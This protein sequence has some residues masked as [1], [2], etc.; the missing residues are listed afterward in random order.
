[1]DNDI[2]KY[3]SSQSKLDKEICELLMQEISKNL[4]KSES[5]IWHG[6]P[7]WFLNGNPVVGYSKQKCGTNLLFWSGQ[8]FDEE[9]LK[10]EGKFK[11]AQVCYT[12]INEVNKNDLKKWL[13]KSINI[14]WDYKNIVKN[15]GKMELLDLS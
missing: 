6:H 13:L 5:K 11:A 12:N 9:G 10:P 1:M 2:L 7:V 4:P 14:Q 3:N 8:S 15:K